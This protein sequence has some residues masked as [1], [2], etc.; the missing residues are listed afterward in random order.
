MYKAHCFEQGAM[1]LKGHSFVCDM[2]FLLR[3][4]FDEMGISAGRVAQGW[5]FSRDKE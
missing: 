1:L 2:V 5:N 3:E 4:M